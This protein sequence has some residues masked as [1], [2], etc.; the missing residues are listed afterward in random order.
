LDKF[1]EAFRRFKRDVNIDNV[2]SWK[3][4]K[5]EFEEWAGSRWKDTSAQLSALGVEA[6]KEGIGTRFGFSRK[7]STFQNWSTCRVEK[8]P[9][10][11]RIEK[12]MKS[13]PYATLG[14][15]RGHRKR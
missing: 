15:A 7:Y 10:R 5:S 6:R 13:H 11:S 4:L 2:D 12:Y 1:P 3:Q 9:Y 8:T 14:E